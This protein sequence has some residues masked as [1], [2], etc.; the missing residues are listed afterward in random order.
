MSRRGF[1]LLEIVVVATVFLVLTGLLF[2]GWNQTMA[3]WGTAGRR[4]DIVGQAQKVFRTLDQAL[5]SSTSS[6]VESQSG[7]LSFASTHG[8]R[9]TP[10]AGS[11]A[12]EPAGEVNFR[13]YLVCNFASTQNQL[14][15]SEFAIPSTHSAFRLPRSL[16]ATDLGFGVQP[17]SYYTSNGRMLAQGVRAFS[18]ELDSRVVTIDLSFVTADGNADFRCSVFLRN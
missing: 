3:A 14:D 9:G 1:S 8:L 5:E 13:R 6:S 10:R 11:F 17:L 16:A 7:I 18:A 15:I 4:A 2:S 12:V